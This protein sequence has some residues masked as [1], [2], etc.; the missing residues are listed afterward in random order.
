MTTLSMNVLSSDA[1]TFVWDTVGM[2]LFLLMVF[3]LGFLVFNSKPVQKLIARPEAADALLTKQMQADLASGNYSEVLRRAGL[4]TALS[5]E[6]LQLVMSALVELGRTGE[7]WARAKAALESVMTLRTPEMVHCILDH[8]VGDVKVL[9]E[10]MEGL[11]ALDLGTDPKSLNILVAAFTDAMHLDTVK[12]LLARGAE[13][14]AKTFVV[15]AKDALKRGDLQQAAT[16][17]GEMREAGLF[18]PAHLLSQVLRA[19]ARHGSEDA[20]LEILSALELTQE[21]VQSLLE[22]AAR[23]APTAVD[24]VRT[25]AAAQNIALNAACFEPMIKVF[26]KWSDPRA[27]ALLDEMQTQGL[28][29]STSLC[30]SV[31]AMCVESKNVPLAEYV[32]SQARM[33]GTA[34]LPLYSTVV[35]VYAATRQFEK[36]CD[37][38]TQLTEDGLEPDTVMYGGLIKAAVECGQLE[39][40]RKL[41]RQ[42]GT[43][44][45]QNYISLFRACGR[46]RN[47]RK[48]LD[49]LKE[50]EESDVGI[51]TTAYNCVLDVCLKSGDMR[52]GTELFAKMKT[53]NFVD[54]ISYN[55]LLK[56]ARATGPLD[57]MSILE[58][59]RSR[60][61]QPN[62]VTYNSLINACVSKGDM[63]TAWSFVEEMQQLS[64]EIDNFTCSIMMKGLK[65]SSSKDDVD[66]TLNLIERSRVR[67]DE[68]LVNTLL[69]A[70]IRLRDVKRLTSAL[71]TFRLSGVVPSEHAYGTL[72]RAYGQARCLPQAQSMWTDML[73]RKVRPSEATF[74][75]M[76]EACVNNGA[77]EEALT[78]LREMKAAIPSFATPAQTYALL[79]KGFAQRKDTTRV[80]EV[81][82]SMQESRVLLDLVTFNCLINACARVGDMEQASQFFREMCTQGVMPD[83]VTYSTVIKG[84]CVQGDLEQ[85][86]QLFTLMRKRGIKPD[87]ILFNAILDGCA[88]KQ[89]TS[90]SELMLADM[91]SSGVAPSNQTLAILVRLYGKCHDLETAQGY[92]ERLPKQY[93]FEVNAQVQASLL[94]AC[95]SCG[96]MK[97]AFAVF[98]QIAH[99]DAKAFSTLITGCLKSGDVAGA[100]RTVERAMD[101]DAKLD[102]ELV[103]NAVFMARRRRIE[104]PMARLQ[105]CGYTVSQ[106]SPRGDAE[107]HSTFHARRQTSQSWREDSE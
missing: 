10:A 83:L 75:S 104:V 59:M 40:S 56:G 58:D 82:R 69:D 38:Y 26:A 105:S 55:T 92:V 32:L 50:L 73:E 62:Q 78:T 87:A 45:I 52:Q 4:M 11:W 70:C 1:T 24:K 23:E 14:S 63:K 107:K 53:L 71:N 15:L 25:M 98:G 103:E 16:H 43:M 77:F 91:E 68:V 90:M 93:G 66:K 74:T 47:V 7:A 29:C 61:L 96:A 97:Q 106:H 17:L 20:A 35:K 79:I 101:A 86:V 84:Y 18:L 21:H 51:D 5:G 88:R 67:P 64:V 65:F 44:D 41:L 2:E 37:I 36:T 81:Y 85:A 48:A 12:T 42:S 57:A 22:C 9:K 80:M 34:N 60:N 54:V 46:E 3:G 99:P 8:L 31:A 94:L 28:S 19:G 76:V 13:C 89:M 100:L 27:F 72:I 30:C 6:A 39:L 95:C 102:A 33:A 49:L